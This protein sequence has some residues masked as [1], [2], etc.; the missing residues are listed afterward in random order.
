VVED[1]EVP[2]PGDVVVAEDKEV[3]RITSVVRSIALG[4][5]IALGYVRREHFEPGSAVAVRLR[6]RLVPARVVELPFVKPAS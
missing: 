3:G 2:A 1:E 6:D 5:P 4:K